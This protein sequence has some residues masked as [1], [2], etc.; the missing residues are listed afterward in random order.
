MYVETVLKIDD[1]KFS[2]KIEN[3]NLLKNCYYFGMWEIK[4]PNWTVN[5]KTT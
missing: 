2:Q 4:F 5:K 3:F 1:K